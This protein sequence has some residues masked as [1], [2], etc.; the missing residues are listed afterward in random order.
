VA[1]VKIVVNDIAASEGGALS[2]LEDLYNKIVEYNDKNEWIFLISDD[3]LEPKDNIKIIKL[4]QIKK[5]WIKRI[6]FDFFHG[7]NLIND[8]APDVYVSLQ[9]TATLGVKMK[10]IVYFH[11]VI[12]FQVDYKFNLFKKKE[13]KLWIYQN[14][15]R[16]VYLKLFE[17]SNADIVVQSKWLAKLMQQNLNNDFYVSQPSVTSELSKF[18]F[19]SMKNKK[20]CRFFFPTSDFVYKNYK[21]IIEAVKI[22]NENHIGGFEV[23]LTLSPEEHDEIANINY[24]GKITR[25]DVYKIMTESVLVF[26]SI[27]ES[28]GLPLIEGMMI[29]CPIIAADL[30]YAHETSD[31]YKNIV[32]FDSNSPH[33]LAEKM[34]N[35]IKNNDYVYSKYN[36]KESDKSELLNIILG[37]KNEYN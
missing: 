19:D 35:M 15:G 17:H 23:I 33:N 16:Y 26:P 21:V 10:Q 30:E 1:K 18:K 6:N 8:L 27:I 20:K 9:N 13:I 22:L 28:Y 4:P 3:Y 37:V 31:G 25:T 24:I 32:F 5:S 14:I 29:G 12:P 34:E 11:Q 2:V 36:R 7:K